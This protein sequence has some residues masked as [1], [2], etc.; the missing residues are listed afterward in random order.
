MGRIRSLPG[1]RRGQACAHCGTP[2][3]KHTRSCAFVVLGRVDPDGGPGH[4]QHGRRR[5]RRRDVADPP[6]VDCDAI[7]ADHPLA[8]YEE[9]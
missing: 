2:A 8:P 9:G 4:R 3:P 5:D 1:Y 6:D 7:P